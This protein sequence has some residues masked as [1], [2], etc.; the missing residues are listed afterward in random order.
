MKKVDQTLWHVFMEN[1]DQNLVV[2]VHQKSGSK[3][4]RPICSSSSS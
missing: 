3:L 2:V 1:L 4:G